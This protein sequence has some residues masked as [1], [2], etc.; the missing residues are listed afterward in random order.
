MKH[1]DLVKIAERYL[2]KSKGCSFVFTELVAA[3]WEIPDAIGWRSGITILIECKANR[4]DFLSDKKKSFRAS[5]SVGMGSFRFYMCPSGLIQRH[6]LPDKWG[7]IGVNEMGKARQLVGPSGNCEWNSSSPFYHSEKNE[8]G[9]TAL[10]VSA[11]RRLHLRGVL[12]LIYE[13]K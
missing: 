1:D 9:E 8:G 6:E 11:L 10:M 2:L 12:S 3:A 7:L 4:E 5:P 13:P